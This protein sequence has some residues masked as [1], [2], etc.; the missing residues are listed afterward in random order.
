MMDEDTLEKLRAD[1]EEDEA[2]ERADS[3]EE[4]DS[5]PY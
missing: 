2:H 3:E 1:A 4:P 5:L